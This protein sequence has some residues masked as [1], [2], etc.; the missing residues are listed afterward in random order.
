VAIL[1]LEKAAGFSLRNKRKL[2]KWICET[3]EKEKR[4]CGDISFVFETDEAVYLVNT[5]YLQHDWYTDVISFDY[6]EGKRVNGD[7][8]ISV[9]RVRENAAR[10]GVTPEEEMRRVIIHGVLHLI[11]YED[12]SEEERKNMT[13]LENKYLALWQKSEKIEDGKV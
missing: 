12:G 9:D 7:I 4:V 3:V 10:F 8:I 1:F 11:G 5:E 6:N 13:R 2:K